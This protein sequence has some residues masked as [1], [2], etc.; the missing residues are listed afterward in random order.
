[1]LLAGPDGGAACE[2]SGIAWRMVGEAGASV[3]SGSLCCRARR[4]RTA[5]AGAEPLR[6]RIPPGA[7]GASRA[8][9]VAC[10]GSEERRCVPPLI[11]PSGSAS[12]QSLANA[13]TACELAGVR[14]LSLPL[15]LCRS[16]SS[17][18]NPSPGS[19]ASSRCCCSCTGLS[20][21]RSSSHS[22]HMPPCFPC[23]HRPPPPL[24]PRPRPP[25][26]C[27]PFRSTSSHGPSPR[28]AVAPSTRAAA[29]CAHCGHRSCPQPPLPCLAKVITSAHRQTITT[30][31]RS[32]SPKMST[33]LSR[34]SVAA[35]RDPMPIMALGITLVNTSARRQ[36]SEGFINP[37]RFTPLSEYKPVQKRS[38]RREIDRFD[39]QSKIGRTGGEISKTSKTLHFLSPGGGCQIPKSFI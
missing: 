38:Y 24:P 31:R 2:F 1:M 39:A 21:A 20:S 36:M 18:P 11:L 27:A 34:S 14:R 37:R 9:L 26:P 5:S 25:P 8:E 33:S 15:C 19:T 32:W 30:S 17:L 10:S 7:D 6:A 35:E 28:C 22:R 16:L 29:G 23:L 3:G 12:N 13:P 4:G